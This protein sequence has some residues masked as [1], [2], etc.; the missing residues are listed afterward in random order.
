MCR[1]LDYSFSTFLAKTLVCCD[2]LC[3]VIA[4]CVFRFSVTCI[5]IAARLSV[6]WEMVVF[7]R[8]GYFCSVWIKV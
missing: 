5:S 6:A 8:G 2:C 1:E 7:L 3:A 4:C